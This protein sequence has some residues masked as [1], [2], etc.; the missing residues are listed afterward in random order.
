MRVPHSTPRPPTMQPKSHACSHWATRFADFAVNPGERATGSTPAAVHAGLQVAHLGDAVH[1]PRDSVRG[2]VVCRRLRRSV[3]GDPPRP[4]CDRRQLQHEACPAHRGSGRQPS[5]VAGGNRAR[6]RQ[7]APP[8]A[9]PPLSLADQLGDA[10]RQAGA[11][12][13]HLDP[14]DAAGHRV[15]AR[16]PGAPTPRPLLPRARLRSRSGCPWPGPGEGDLPTRPASCPTV[17]PAARRPAPPRSGTRP[18]RSRTRARRGRRPRRG[19]HGAIPPIRAVSRSSSASAARPSS[20][21]IARSRAGSS[22]PVRAPSSSP[23]LAAV[24]GPRSS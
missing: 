8:P 24:S 14:R 4:R 21:S 15:H 18:R 6:D 10:R 12:V 17:A 9:A 11:G 23:S 3:N 5:S 1:F 2:A 20:R 19:R 22:S 16:R 7:P 13:R